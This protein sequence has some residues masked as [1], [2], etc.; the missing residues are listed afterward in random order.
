MVDP[1]PDR[2]AEPN[3][4]VVLGELQKIVEKS[5]KRKKLD[6]DVRGVLAILALLGAFGLAFALLFRGAAPEIP[7]WAAA[8]VS[9]VTGFYFG[10]R[11]GG[12]VNGNGH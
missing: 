9:G 11:A 4:D 6:L 1:Q 2:R 3:H 12:T 8:L 10:S 5:L 7:T